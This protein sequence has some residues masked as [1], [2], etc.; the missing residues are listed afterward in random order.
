MPLFGGGGGGGPAGLGMFAQQPQPEGGGFLEQFEQ[1]MQNPYVA[2]ALGAG[3]ALLGANDSGASLG[4]ALR[5]GLMGGA[6]SL[7]GA[8]R[9]R[10]KRLEEEE[11]S[12]IMRDLIERYAGLA[13][14]APAQQAQQ[15]PAVPQPQ[16]P[17]FG[18]QQQGGQF[19]MG[20]LY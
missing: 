4:Q 9:A 13:N 14:R 10:Q 3:G 8:S 6:G 20:G 12:K 5:Q 17:M 1:N 2:A 18:A 7:Y 16:G 19:P 15:V 11:R